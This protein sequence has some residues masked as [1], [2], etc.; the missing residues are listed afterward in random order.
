MQAFHQQG[1]LA[2]LTLVEAGVP[3][4]AVASREQAS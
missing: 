2:G 3:G 1:V 4:I